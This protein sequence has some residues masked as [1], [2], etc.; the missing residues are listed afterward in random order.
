M[1]HF[2]VKP[3]QTAEDIVSFDASRREVTFRIGPTN[4]S[5]TLPQTK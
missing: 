3:D 1:T 5:Y 2:S 4:Y